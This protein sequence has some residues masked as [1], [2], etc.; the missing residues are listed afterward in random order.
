MNDGLLENYYA[1]NYTHN[2]QCEY[3]NIRALSTLSF[4]NEDARKLEDV[5]YSKN[6]EQIFFQMRTVVVALQEELLRLTA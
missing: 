4:M 6:D 2:N 3:N 5:R 1:R